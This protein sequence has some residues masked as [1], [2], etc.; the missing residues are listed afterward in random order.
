[1]KRGELGEINTED[2]RVFIQEIQRAA[3]VKRLKYLHIMELWI[4]NIAVTLNLI[5]LVADK[6][7]IASRKKAV[8]W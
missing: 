5:G 6:Y 3:G 4:K 1:M 7:Y 8:R 2:L